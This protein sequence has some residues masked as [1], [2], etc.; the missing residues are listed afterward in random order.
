M[1]QEEY[2]VWPV[3]KHHYRHENEILELPAGWEFVP[4][5]DAML[6]RR[7]KAS[8]E[9]WL[10]QTKY[11]NK[12]S[13]CGVCVPSAICQK[14]KEEI[15]LERS[16]PR[17]QQKLASGREYRAKKEAEYAD[18]FE[19]A[20]LTFLH[21]APRWQELAQKLAHAV[22]VHATPVGSG[23]VARTKQ[24]PVEQRAE[25]ALIAWMRH[26][27]TS[28]DHMYIERARGERRAVRR[29]LAGQSR[30]ILE[31]YRS[32]DDFDYENDPLYL[33]LMEPKTH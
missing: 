8:G 12:I 15:A 27:T 9:Y 28:Y 2:K 4:S 14:I 5:G 23:T 30:E 10:V 32:G 21:F 7:L 13:S 1:M 16:D 22:A 25:A 17:Y 26:Q 3:G 31:R 24:I 11:K 33:A 6:T 19:Q 29:M 20:V 18:D